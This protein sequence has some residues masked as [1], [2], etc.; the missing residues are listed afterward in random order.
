MVALSWNKIDV[1]DERSKGLEGLTCG[2]KAENR[3]EVGGHML[4][5]VRK[6]NLG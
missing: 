3:L 6:E 4:A 2:D 5:C 1:G